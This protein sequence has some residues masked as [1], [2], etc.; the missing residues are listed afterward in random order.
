MELYAIRVAVGVATRPANVNRI[1]IFTDS[2]PC[3]KR[4]VDPSL[5]SGQWHSLFVCS[6]LAK[7]LEDR[8][9]RKIS[10][11]QVPSSLKWGPHQEAHEYAAGLDVN[12][13]R[14]HAHGVSYAECRKSADD[15]SQTAWLVEYDFPPYIGSNFLVSKDLV[16]RPVKPTTVKGGPWLQLIGKDP[17]LFARMCRCILN[18]API[19]AYYLRYN[20]SE[21]IRCPCGRVAVQTR[22]HML[23]SCPLISYRG[24]PDTIGQL[25]DLLRLNPLAFGFNRP[26]NGVG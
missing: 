21:P 23:H 12:I 4:A 20:I 13:G 24:S 18:H 11:V 2:L 14:R 6:T 8:P 7:W 25:A 3:A 15:F 22:A 1:V 26:R 17:Q 5:H 9:D 16:G 19:G 10:F